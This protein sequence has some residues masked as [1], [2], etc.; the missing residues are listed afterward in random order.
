MP[1]YI[2]VTPLAVRGQRDP[3]PPGSP[4]EMDETAGRKLVSRGVLAEATGTDG[5]AQPSA[6]DTAELEAIIRDLERRVEDT[7][8]ALDQQVAATKMVEAQRDAA[9]T[10]ADQAEAALVDARAAAAPSAVKAS[11]K[12]AG[13]G[14]D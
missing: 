6:P 9:A 1:T 4:V 12:A 7:Q 14:K 11:A 2:V 8:E 5:A 3:L 13:K 10:R